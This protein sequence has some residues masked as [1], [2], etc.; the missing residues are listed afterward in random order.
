MSCPWS[1][2]IFRRVAAVLVMACTRPCHR[3]AANPS[4]GAASRGRLL[5]RLY[6]P[7][8]RQPGRRSPSRCCA[9]YNV[10]RLNEQSLGEKSMR[11]WL[12]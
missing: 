5:D 9:R 8:L 7:E 3:L 6:G 10:L 2:P 12:E 1:L 4:G 11:V